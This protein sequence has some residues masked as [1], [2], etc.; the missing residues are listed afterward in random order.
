MT[1]VLV[2]FDNRI[3]T[4]DVSPSTMNKLGLFDGQEVDSETWQKIVEAEVVEKL[5]AE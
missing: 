1:F 5:A 2:K 3:S 4:P